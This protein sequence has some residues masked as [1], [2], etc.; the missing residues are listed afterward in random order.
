[1]LFRSLGGMFR[2]DAL[3][4]A[5]LDIKLR[6]LDRWHEARRRNA[7]IYNEMLAGTP[8]ITPSIEPANYSIYNQYV[9]RLP[10][11]DAVKA[12][13]A[14]AGVGSAIYYPISLHVQECFLHLGGNEGDL[15]TTEQ[16]CREV[17]ALP[18]YPEL[19]QEQVRYAAS[20]V[21]EALGA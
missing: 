16:A 3:Q 15:P 17:L 6:H 5:V 8:A 9:V 1:M 20:G 7:S 18:V 4:A 14:A 11:R 13:L 10:N 21:R 19:T 12:K 2:L